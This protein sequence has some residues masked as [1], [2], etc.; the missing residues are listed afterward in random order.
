MPGIIDQIKWTP[1]GGSALTLADVNAGDVLKVEHFGGNSLMGN[2]ALA[3]AAN[4]A[5]LPHGNISGQF[6]FTVG[7]SHDTRQDA[8]SYAVTQY[9]LL[10]GKGTLVWNVDAAVTTAAGALLSGVTAA[11]IEGTRWGLRYTFTITTLVCSIT[12]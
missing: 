5:L 8:I 2:V 7:T 3:L 6:V 9:N 11:Q 1:A 10:N 12:G 4:P